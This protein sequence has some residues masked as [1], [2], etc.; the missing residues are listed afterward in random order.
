MTRDVNMG[1]LL[2]IRFRNILVR[3]K[4]WRHGYHS[5]LPHGR[6][7]I[8]VIDLPSYDKKQWIVMVSL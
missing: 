2:S 8:Q 1:L 6:K 7:I 5:F 4:L 3:V